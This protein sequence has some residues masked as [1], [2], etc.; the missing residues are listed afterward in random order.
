MYISVWPEHMYVDRICV[1]CLQRPEEGKGSPQPSKG[2][3]DGCKLGTEL[4]LLEEQ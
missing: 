1:W 2:V 3:I 4:G